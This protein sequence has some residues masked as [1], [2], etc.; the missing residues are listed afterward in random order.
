MEVSSV[1]TLEK[2]IC[3]IVGIRKAGLIVLT[4]DLIQED[5][6]FVKHFRV[7]M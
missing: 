2:S 7:Q 5:A 3:K 1:T 4:D 6:S